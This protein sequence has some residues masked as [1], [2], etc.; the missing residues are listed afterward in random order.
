MR[1]F[2]RPQYQGSA[3]RIPLLYRAPLAVEAGPTAGTAEC[4]VDLT[5]IDR[6]L[7][8]EHPQPNLT[9]V[10]AQTAYSL[11]RNP[12]ELWASEIA[13]ALNVSDRTAVRWRTAP[14]NTQTEEAVAP[15]PNPEWR[16]RA[17]CRGTDPDLFFPSGYTRNYD[18][19]IEDAK[20]ICST[21]PVKQS[22]L[23]SAMTIEGSR[24]SEFRYG[25]QGGTTPAERHALYERRR[26]AQ[27]RAAQQLPVE[28]LEV[29]A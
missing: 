3:S 17:A 1:I 9:Q 21:C 16:K 10:E 5:A 6:A 24:R 14:T 8:G 12:H 26:K 7:S 18:Q 4:G 11:I 19:Q 20:D 2:D 27:N 22:C 28:A 29:A 25:V 23:E 13:A 15:Q